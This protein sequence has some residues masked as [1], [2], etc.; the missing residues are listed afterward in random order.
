MR[1]P[2]ST[3]RTLLPRN[4]KEKRRMEL[5]GGLSIALFVLLIVALFFAASLQQRT[6]RS[7]SIAAVVAAI[8]AELA[9]ADREEHGLEKLAINPSL[10]A[11][12][13]AKANDMATKSYF[14]HTSPEGIDPWYWFKKEGY[15][16]AYAGENLAVH[17]SDSGDVERAWMDSPTHRDNIMANR[18]TEI[19]IAT[20]QGT[21]EGYPTTFVVQVFGAP[22]AG[23][24][25]GDAA[26]SEGSEVAT[27]SGSDEQ[28][29]GSATQAP[30]TST[31]EPAVA[32][33]R[34]AE[35]SSVP[36]WGYIVAFPRE[37]LR[38]TYYAL[39]LF[40]LL[41]LIR[42]TRFEWRAHHQKKA[43]RAG[44]LLIAMLVLFIAADYFFFVEPV[45][46]HAL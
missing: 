33:A 39:G 27:V 17:F 1:R 9:N 26:L 14:A 41:A 46:A 37:A 3:L 18:Y 25:A 44:A 32:A 42:E 7:P 11:V 15:A 36:L 40:I 28:V 23:A 35:V 21:Y 6:L 38:Y 16:Y 34:A 13:Q 30:E 22:A 4:R 8:L 31:I 19:G 24:A 5:F 10:V 43:Y 45:L 20:A 29:L 2:A 12:A